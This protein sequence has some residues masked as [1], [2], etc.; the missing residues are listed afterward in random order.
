MSSKATAAWSFVARTICS[1]LK[2]LLSLGCLPSVVNKMRRCCPPLS[3]TPCI[4]PVPFSV[5]DSVGLKLLS[6]ESW[7]LRGLGDDDKCSIARD[8]IS[9][10][11][12]MVCCIQETK[13]DVTTVFKA[14]SFLPTSLSEFVTVDVD[15]SRGG[16]LTAWDTRHLSL[17]SSIHRNFSLTTV[18]ASTVSNLTFSL[19]N[20]YAPRTTAAPPS[21]S[22]RCW[23]WRP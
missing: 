11:N 3:P 6:L 21:L 8:A 22:A 17:C 18:L 13:L 2:A 1:P 4:P 19:T 5:M 12:P 20:V 9:L 15:G 23:R 16:M 10:A 7:N 14:C